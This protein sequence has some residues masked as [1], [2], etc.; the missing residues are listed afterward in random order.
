MPAR[1]Y[2]CYKNFGLHG[3][4]GFASRCTDT[5]SAAS[6]LLRWSFILNLP[7]LNEI[8]ILAVDLDIVKQPRSTS[9]NGGEPLVNAD[10]QQQ[11]LKREASDTEKRRHLL[12]DTRRAQT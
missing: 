8:S 4:L 9:G 2:K 12:G 11:R 10:G 3:V 5:I 6:S 7:T 1:V